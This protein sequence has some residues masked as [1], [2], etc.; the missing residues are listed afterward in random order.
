MYQIFYDNE[1]FVIL[2]DGEQNSSGILEL[3]DEKSYILTLLPIYDKTLFLPISSSVRLK[4]N[5]LVCTIPHIKLDKKQF[6]LTPKLAPYIPVTNS[7]IDMQREFGEHTITIYTDTVPKLLIE[8]LKN[9]VTVV[10]PEYP[11]KLQ[12]AVLDNGILF[13]CLCK[14]YICVVFFDYNDYIVLVDK[15]CDSYVFDESGITITI[16]L[17]DNQ[18]RKYV[19]HLVFDNKEYICDKEY[20]E[21]NSPHIPHDKLLGYDFMQAILAEDYDYCKRLLAPNCTYDEEQLSQMFENLQDIII[22]TI[23]V[24]NNCI[25]AYINNK[26]TSVQF[27]IQNSL[28]EKIILM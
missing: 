8:N 14:H 21:Y 22:P 27:F 12:E 6:F 25:F 2:V 15:E 26:V 11:E 17:N 3:D 9:F 23:P 7:H 19:S 5:S 4:N 10:I 13:Y 24:K 1:Q 16:S 18:G 28:I 20:F